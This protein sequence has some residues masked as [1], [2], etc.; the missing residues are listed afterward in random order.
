MLNAFCCCTCRFLNGLLPLF[1]LSKNTTF[2]T[3]IVTGLPE[4]ETELL[5]LEDQWGLFNVT[6]PAG[7]KVVKASSYANSENEE[8]GI[9]S[10]SWLR[11]EDSQQYW[12]SAYAESYD[13]NLDVTYVGVT[14]NK[15]Y[16]LFV[17]G[18]VNG[19]G[20]VSVS[21]SYSASINQKTPTVTDY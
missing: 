21:L 2:S 7:V 6:I 18:V 1:I 5:S 15:T 11:N 16:R 19:N 12:T 20:S 17:E 4:K 14:P 9:S 13:S 3:S 10:E 8:S